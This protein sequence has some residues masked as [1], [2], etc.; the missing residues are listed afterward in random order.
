MFHFVPGVP[1]V[2]MERLTPALINRTIEM[3]HLQQV[4]EC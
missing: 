3:T 1:L 2:K 4:G